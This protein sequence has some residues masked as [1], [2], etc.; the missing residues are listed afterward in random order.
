MFFDPMYLMVAIPCMIL[1]G[2]AT[3]LTKSTF[4]KYSKVAASSGLT[5]HQAARRMLDSQGLA[6]VQIERVQ[7]FLSD[8]YDP[9]HRVLRLSP[10]V[11][12]SPS[13]S[14][15]GVACH[16]AGHALQHANHYAPLKLR[17]A[18]VPATSFSSRFSYILLMAG[19]FL[20][21]PQLAN[22]GLLCFALSVAF[23]VVT[24]PVE[25]DASARAKKQLVTAG[26]VTPN[27]QVQAGRV[28]NA[29]FM[30]YV[31]SAI[32]ALMTFLYFFLRTR[33]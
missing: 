4:A 21:I 15:V 11:Y 30:T 7:G 24:L 18:M 12:D 16:E 32:T 8:H 14:A 1:A 22:L 27:E 33:R 20:S 26:I 29:A 5:G 28:L 25:W 3:M 31:A 6:D 19:L 9:R 13:L 10:P 23:S 17:S 2:I